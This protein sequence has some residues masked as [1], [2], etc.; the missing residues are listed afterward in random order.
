MSKQ[1]GNPERMIGEFWD[2]AIL[3]ELIEQ[4]SYTFKIGISKIRPGTMAAQLFPGKTHFNVEFAD[5]STSD[6]IE[7]GIHRRTFLEMG[8]G[9]CCARHA[10]YFEE[11]RRLKKLR[12][13]WNGCVHDP[14]ALKAPCR[15]CMAGYFSAT[16]FG[17]M[18]GSYA[19]AV[20][21]EGGGE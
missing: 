19:H 3:T 7:R 15:L 16:S 14:A 2:Y 13:G 11:V 9:M 12:E 5:E 21:G 18:A 10:Q 6:V 8:T 1:W 20:G 17:Q 4:T